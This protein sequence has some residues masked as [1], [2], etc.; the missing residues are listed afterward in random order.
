M[1]T[2]WRW[3]ISFLVWLSADPMAADLEAARAAAAAS[4]AR[5]SMAVDAPAPPTPTP[6]ECDCGKTCVR[7]VWK[8]DG[9]IAQPCKCQCPRCKAERAKGGAA[10]PDGK[11]PRVEVQGY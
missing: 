9:K 2:V 8:P 3:L 5:A 1:A 11:C 10:C 6:T 7:G 4:V